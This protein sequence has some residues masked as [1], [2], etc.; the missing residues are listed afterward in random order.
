M[1]EAQ[2]I[3]LWGDFR[4]EYLLIGNLRYL[5]PETIPFYIAS[6]TLP[7]PVLCDISEILR[8]RPNKTEHVTLS[9][10]RPDI[11]LA[12]RQIQHPN[13]TFHDLAFLLPAGD[14]VEGITSPPEP[15]LAFFDSQKTTEQAVYALQMLLPAR[16]RHKIRYFHAG[17]SDTYRD[18]EYES[19]QSGAIWGLFATKAFGLVSISE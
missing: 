3:S 18:D 4:K 12:V 16:L 19:L 5:I 7:S 13:H 15:F 1:D 8:L 6:A 10:D 17:M 9:C 14:Y 2:C 11:H